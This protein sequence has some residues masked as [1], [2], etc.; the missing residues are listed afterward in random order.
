MVGSSARPPSLKILIYSMNFWPEP[1]G[2]GKYSGEMGAWLAR[3]GH[4]VRAI[5]SAPYYPQWQ[6]QPGYSGAKYQQES[7]EGVDVRRAPAWIPARPKALTRILYLLI[8]AITSLP[9]LIRSLF[10]KPDLIFVVEPP[11]FCAP[12]AWLAARCCGA[13]CWIHIQDFE[14]DAAL[15][16]G[17]LKAPGLQRLTYGLERWLLRR[18]DRRSTISPRMLDRLNQKTGTDVTNVH[19]PNWV[20]ISQIAPLSRP[21]SFRADL[22][23]RS[24][25]KVALYSGNMGDKQGLEIVIEAARILQS[26]TDLIFVMCGAGAAYERLRQLGKEL[27]NL[28]WLPVQPI[29]KLNELLNLAD[30]HLLPQRADAADLVMPSK[31]TGMLASGRPVLATALPQTQVY[32]LVQQVGRLTPPGNAEQFALALT[33]MIDQTD[34]RLRQ[35]GESRR[36]AESELGQDAI[37]Q[38]YAQLFEQCLTSERIV[39]T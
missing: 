22:N 13:K 20:D 26:R 14:I 39:V 23:L 18:F 9:S 33:E 6:V 34:E 10:W 11:F 2:I 3:N 29:E 19:C 1:T 32:E 7:W 17:I 31:L 25:Q 21:S 5:C 27:P 38:K 35:G 37:L 30:V 4:E 36:I 12:A 8:F 16:L 24:D 28:I 15:D